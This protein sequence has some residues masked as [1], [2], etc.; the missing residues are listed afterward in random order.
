MSQQ[1]TATPP[2]GAPRSLLRGDG[3]PEA[4]PRWRAITERA[5]RPVLMLHRLLRR[6][7]RAARVCALV[8]CLNAVSWS[9]I[10]PPFQTL[11]EPSHFAYVQVLAESGRPPTTQTGSFSLEEETALRDLHQ[12]GVLW[13]PEHHTISTPAQQRRLQEGLTSPL[14]RLGERSGGVAA[15]EPPLYYALEAIPY[16]LAAS[17]TLL[18]RLALMRLLSALMAGVTALFTYMFVR[19]VLPSRPWAW[20]VGGFAASLQPLLGFMSGSVNP[21]ALLYAVS[22]A[23]FYCLARAF[24]RGLS[25]RLAVAIGALTAIGLLTKL[26]FLGLLPGLL[27]GLIIV[28]RRS[29]KLRPRQRNLRRSLVLAAALVALPALAYI[30]KSLLAGQTGLDL[31]SSAFH[32]TSQASP[33][34]EVAYIW[35]MYLPHLPGTRHYFAGLLTTRDV[36]FNRS[37][38]LYGW[39]DTSFPTWVNTAALIPAGIVAVL[40]GRTLVLSRATLR[41]RVLELGVYASMTIGLMVLIGA[42]SYLHRTSEGSGWLQPRYLLPL[43]PLFGAAISIA[44]RGAGRRLGPAIGVLLMLLVL[45]HD[46]FSQLQVIARFYG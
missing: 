4:F 6:I 7:P 42:D 19:E 1:D 33:L 41:H 13:H 34:Q 10:T 9:L 8:A 11:D 15:T 18:D 27:L 32:L 12:S 21:D 20:T 35:N 44:A 40:A 46:I 16:K 39:L 2:I 17:G 30:V 22:A 31:L 14:D 29:L 43:L 5:S 24:A 25:P 45:A 23:V 26:N 28:S 3:K 36:W 37:V 38:G